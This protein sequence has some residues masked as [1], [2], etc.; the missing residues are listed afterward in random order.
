MM[1]YFFHLSDGINL[2]L[3]A[4]KFEESLLLAGKSCRA[5]LKRDGIFNLF[6]SYLIQPIDF[7]KNPNLLSKI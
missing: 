2:W 3:T 4:P 7:E 5:H 6:S 1:E